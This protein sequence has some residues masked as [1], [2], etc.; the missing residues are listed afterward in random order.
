MAIADIG[1]N[2]FDSAVFLRARS[3]F[4]GGD[5]ILGAEAN[6]SVDELVVYE[7]C[8]NQELTVRVERGPE[9]VL[10]ESM[11][12]GLEVGGTATVFEDYSFFVPFHELEPFE[13]FFEIP[14]TIFSDDIPEG[15]ETI[16]IILSTA[17]TCELPVIEIE[18]REIEP[19]ELELQATPAC[20]GT[21]VLISSEIS[22]GAPDYTYRWNN[23]STGTFLEVDPE[24][25]EFY[26]L[27]VKDDCGSEIHDTIFLDIL[28]APFA[29]SLI[30]I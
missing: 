20:E 7:N 5:A 26:S 29:L 11:F 28:E 25:R 6:G 1:D 4:A 13:D 3:F 27:I 21:N 12:I 23:G 18:I 19:L 17:C 30:H 9:S 10:E 15:T 22:G 14:I 8:G 24:D 16:E 2:G